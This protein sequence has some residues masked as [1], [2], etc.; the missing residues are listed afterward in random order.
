M[1]IPSTERTPLHSKPT[2]APPTLN[3]TFT[4]NL[5]ITTILLTISLFFA[6]FSALVTKALY[7]IIMYVTR[8]TNPD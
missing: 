8:P 5:F 7:N 1:A 4:H 2:M 6:N 3:H